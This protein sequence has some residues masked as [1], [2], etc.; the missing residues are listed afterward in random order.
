M[1][2]ILPFIHLAGIA[3]LC[4][5]SFFLAYHNHTIFWVAPLMIVSMIWNYGY[6]KLYV[7]Y[8]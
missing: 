3:G 5:L 8:K 6:Q 7:R 2:T 1:K 4:V